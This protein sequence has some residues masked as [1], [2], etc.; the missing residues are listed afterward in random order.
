M[1]V[2][3][4]IPSIRQ[5]IQKAKAKNKKIGFVPTMGALHEGHLSLI[6]K[7]KKENDIT[8]LSIFVNPTQ[9]APTEDWTK[10][11]RTLRQDIL[12]A[13]KENVDII[14]HPSAEEMYP[15]GYGEGL[16]CVEVEKLGSILCGKFRP[17]HFR[18]VAT[19]VGK[20]LNIVGPESMYLGQK[21]FQ[22]TVVLKKMVD[23]LNF[24]VTIK[25]CPTIREQ[26][27]L[28]LSS[29]NVYLTQTQRKEAPILFESLKQAKEQI[30]KGE[31]DLE[32]ITQ[33]IK[34][35]IQKNSSGKVQYVECVSLERGVLIALAVFLGRTRLIDNIIVKL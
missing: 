18:G 11:P 16:T 8:V 2:V 13:K 33:G 23:D 24:P 22:Q 25:V 21:D 31:R 20:L 7:S 29:R 19:I 4:T 27:G 14:F 17:G 32:K 9:F 1:Q 34:K 10:Y 28:A 35:N 3:E 6:R 30:L 5:L 15:E 12:L 26:D